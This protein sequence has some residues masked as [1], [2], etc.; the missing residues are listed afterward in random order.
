DQRDQG[1][2]GPDTHGDLATRPLGATLRGRLGEPTHVLV[3]VPLSQRRFEQSSP[4]CDE[5]VHGDSPRGSSSPSH[6]RSFF[7]APAIRRL[8][9]ASEHS[10]WRLTCSREY[11]SLR[12]S[13]AIRSATGR[14]SSAFSRRWSIKRWSMLPSSSAG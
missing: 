14:S 2:G 1:H 9:V 13:Q 8:A 4:S 3:R 6:E 10:Q 12:S 11:P 7:W 5:F